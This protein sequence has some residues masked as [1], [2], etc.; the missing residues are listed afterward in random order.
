MSVVEKVRLAPWEVIAVC[1]TDN[2]SPLIMILLNVL[3]TASGCH[4]FHCFQWKHGGSRTAK[5]ACSGN[6]REG[7]SCFVNDYWY[8][9]LLSEL[10]MVQLFSTWQM[11]WLQRGID[12]WV[13][14]AGSLFKH[15]FN[16][17]QQKYQPGI[18]H[19]LLQC[20]SFFLWCRTEKVNL[21]CW[22]CVSS[23]SNSSHYWCFS[24]GFPSEEVVEIVSASSIWLN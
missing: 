6:D 8:L 12:T 5:V 10:M 20:S 14:G 23:F 21:L 7:C 4:F 1:A 18:M 3:Q 17:R 19:S 16:S 2:N 22:S 24:S 9:W 15:L 11:V 13:I